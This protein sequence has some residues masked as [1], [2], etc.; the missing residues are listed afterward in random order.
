M[1]TRQTKAFAFDASHEHD[2]LILLNTST[3]GRHRR[4]CWTI[5]L[6]ARGNDLFGHSVDVAG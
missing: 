1:M 6:Q 4:K 3:K 5:A 2:R